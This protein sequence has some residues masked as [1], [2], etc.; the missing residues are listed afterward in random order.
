MS[1]RTQSRRALALVFIALFVAIQ[2]LLWFAYYGHGAK[3]LIGDEA[4]YQASAIAILGGGPWMPSTIWPPLQPLMLAA[5]Y[6]VVGVHL[7]AVQTVQTVLFIG[8]AA[9]LRGLW[10]RIGGSVAA[11]NTTAALF[12][13]NPATAAYAQWL[14][15]EIVHLF[16]LLAVFWLLARPLSRFGSSVAGTCV[17]LAI[18]AKSL[19]APFW[20]LF[21]I[22]FVR[23]EKPRFATGSA[24]VF[25]CALALVTGPALVHGWRSFG[26]PMIADS[27]IYNL[28]VGLTDQW[29]SDY[30]GDMG[31][32]TLPAFLAS[33]TTPQQRNAVYLDKVRGVIAE[34]GIGTVLVDQLSRQYFRLFSAKTPLLSQLPGPACAGH[35]SIYTSAPWLT[36]TL[37]ALNDLS[38]ALMLLAAAF[39]IACWRWRNPLRAFDPRQGSTTELLIALFFA[40]QLA[41]FALIHVKARFALPMIP[42]LCGFGGSFLVALRERAR[43]IGTAPT[44]MPAHGPM[45]STS[46]AACIA[47]SES[48]PMRSPVRL[49]PLRLAIGA[50]LAALLLF[51]AFAGPAL[52]QLCAR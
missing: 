21:L 5:I 27:S 18:L 3:P 20:P 48:L 25:I 17:G 4:S 44:V 12:L 7:L 49:T 34:R 33:G 36:R 39:G 50:V 40:Y 35:L 15:P 24:V 8:C 47:A 32:A 45:N 28:W 52:D 26:K 31:G 23:R 51:L 46:I 29:R 11:A 6:A 1:A 9:L 10:R 37:T 43:L 2:T 13:L 16:L 38:H 22:A 30:V 19:L 41:L 42:F 14:W